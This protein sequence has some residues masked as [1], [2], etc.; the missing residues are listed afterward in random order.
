MG[1]HE[2]QLSTYEERALRE[3][4]EFLESLECTDVALILRTPA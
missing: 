1:A 3:V 2:R 4:I